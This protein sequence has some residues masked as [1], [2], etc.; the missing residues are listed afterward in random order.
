MLP[1]IDRGI[2]SL[3]LAL[4]SGAEEQLRTGAAARNLPLDRYREMLQRRYRNAIGAL[5]GE[6]APL[7]NNG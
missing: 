2:V 1:L 6:S 3:E 7:E 4:G 5:D